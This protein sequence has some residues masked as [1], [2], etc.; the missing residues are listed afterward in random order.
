MSEDDTT[1]FISELYERLDPHAHLVPDHFTSCAESCSTLNLHH[2]ISNWELMNICTGLPDA[3][4]AS[5]IRELADTMCDKSD[6]ASLSYYFLQRHENETLITE[7]YKCKSLMEACSSIRDKS[8]Q[9]RDEADQLIEEIKERITTL[10]TLANADKIFDSLN[11]EIQRV[12]AEEV[13]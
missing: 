9:H 6:L 3:S 1:E 13:K 7:K 8:T 5:M 12:T 4:K 2:M 10:A 11:D